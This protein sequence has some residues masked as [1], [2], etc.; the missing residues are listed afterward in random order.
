MKLDYSLQTP[1]ER[2]SCVETLISQTPD[3]QLTKQYLSYM[4][5]Y[6]LFT[7][8][9]NQTKK[10]KKEEYPTLTKNREITINKRQVSFEEIVSN[11]ENGEDGIY[12]LIRNDKNQILDPKDP[13]NEKD[14]SQVPGLKEQLDII[15]SLKDQF[16]KATGSNKFAIKK[17]IIETWQQIYILKASFRQNISKGRT[18]SHVRN[19]AHA[20][21]EEN[22]HLDEKDM[23]VSDAIISLFNPAHVSFLLCYYSQLREEC[24]DDLN[25]DMHFLLM[26]LENLVDEALAEE[27]LLYS[28]LIWKIDGLTNAEIQKEMEREYGVQHS[29]QYYSSVW[30]QRI[31]KLIAE[32]AKKNYLIWYFTNEE[33]GTWKYC[34]QCGQYKLAHPMF[35]AKNSSKSGFYSMCKNCK[36]KR[37]RNKKA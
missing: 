6:I 30:R 11:L 29:E 20:S 36:N 7:G 17:Q 12:A 15:A 13:I 18:S 4:S 23:P 9:K 28:I 3:E 14:I 21:I 24:C 26:D 8:D 25:S 31:P 37:S 22:I 16:K 35:F 19:L 33:Y 2:I 10:E 5:N 27:E 34:N 1:Q 32:Q